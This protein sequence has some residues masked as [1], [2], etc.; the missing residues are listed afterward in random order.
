MASSLY[1]LLS[2]SDVSSDDDI[3]AIDNHTDDITNIPIA[4]AV[5]K[6]RVFTSEQAFNKTLHK[7]T[8]VMNQ[9]CTK[10]KHCAFGE[11]HPIQ[12]DSDAEEDGAP[13]TT[14]SHKAKSTFYKCKDPACHFKVKTV[15]CA[16]TCT[17]SITVK[18]R[19]HKV[20]LNVKATI[21]SLFATGMKPGQVRHRLL[22]H[23]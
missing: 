9:V 17:F 4:A 10:Q 21:N 2:E 11:A 15:A 13:D 5:E 14:V 16:S 6:V 12:I 8:A 23:R 3:T 20:P 19:L 1:T 7:K 18:A 22:R